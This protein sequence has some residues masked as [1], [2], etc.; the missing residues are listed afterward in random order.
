MMIAGG[1]GWRTL[2]CDLGHWRDPWEDLSEGQGWM[3]G[4][5]LLVTNGVVLLSRACTVHS[6]HL[7]TGKTVTRQ[8]EV[9]GQWS[10]MTPRS[11]RPEIINHVTE[12]AWSFSWYSGDQLWQRMLILNARHWRDTP[13]HFSRRIVIMSEDQ[14]MCSCDYRFCC[15]FVDWI[16]GCDD[17]LQESRVAHELE[18]RVVITSC[19]RRRETRGI[20]SRGS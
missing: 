14:T 3:I 20:E 5:V 9:A 11:M 7:P 13:V 16:T 4:V 10:C 17:Y 19:S 18:C 8:P 12:K 15:E 1:L 2:A 6:S